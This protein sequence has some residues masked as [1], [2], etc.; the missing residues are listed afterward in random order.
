MKPKHI[1]VVSQYFHPEYFRINDMCREWVKRGYKVTVVTGIPN[2]PKGKFYKG[3]SW[4]KR[5]RETWHGIEII[6]IPLLARG[7]TVVQ[8]ILN[9]A[10]FVLS[11]FLWQRFTSTE[12][13]LAFT[14]EVSPMTQAL[15]GVKYSKRKKIPHYLYVQDLWPENVETIT[16][17]HH[18]II[19][20]PLRHMVDYI[21]KNCDKIFA[22]SPPFVKEIQKRI[23]GEE[24]KVIYWPQYAED[25]YVPLDKC[26]NKKVPSDE[27]FKIAFTGNIGK[28]QGLELL[29]K[30]A[31]LLKDE[32]FTDF[33]FVIVGDGRNKEKLLRDIRKKDVA[34]YFYMI[35]RQPAE[36]ISGILASCDAAF[37][38]FS[39]EPLFE[40][41]IP[42]KLQSYMAC[43]M[44]ILA[45]ASGET[46]RLIE[47][48]DCGICC[49]LG[50]APALAEG[51]KALMDSD[52]KCMSEK[53]RK[54]FEDNFRKDRLMDEMD[55]HFLAVL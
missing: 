30:A 45:A 4:F 13:D 5:R 3:Y 8:M 11:G 23:P 28:A 33:S 50:D 40:K 49:G 10:S 2:Y 27:K 6:R 44:P 7:R 26:D 31:K 39:P 24:E 19:I 1:L 15:I 34:E 37:V 32:N 47:E 20:K 43:G 53:S 38:S 46:K 41:T 35:D 29:P 9:Y 17:I 22:T 48:S 21:Y 14:F 55:E 54:Y 51:I 36:E 12:A 18:P 16:G 52:L 42:A 25:F